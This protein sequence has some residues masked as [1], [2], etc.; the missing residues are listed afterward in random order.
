MQAVIVCLEMIVSNYNKLVS[1]G[2][3]LETGLF[4]YHQT[5]NINET[6]VGNTIVDH[7]DVVGPSPVADP[8]T[9]SSPT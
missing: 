8:A 9:S 4:E 2:K 7:S 3:M 5:S 1:N 6:L